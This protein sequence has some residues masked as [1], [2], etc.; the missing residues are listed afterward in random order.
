MHRIL[1]KRLDEKFTSHNIIQTLKAMNLL[2]IIGDGY[3]PT[4]TKTDLTDAYIQNL[5]LGQTMK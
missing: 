5:N 2:E 3:I 1:E 4:Y